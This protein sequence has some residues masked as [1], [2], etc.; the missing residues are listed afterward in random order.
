MVVGLAVPK[1]K[2]TGNVLVLFSSQQ[3]EQRF[4][5][6]KPMKLTYGSAPVMKDKSP[7]YSIYQMA[8]NET[9]QYA[10]IMA[11]LL[12]FK[13]IWIGIIT[14]DDDNGERMVQTLSSI[15]SQH[16]ICIA[17]IERC[18]RSNF[19]DESTNMMQQGARIF[20]KIMESKSNVFVVFGQSYSVNDLRWL[21][22]L[23]PGYWGTK[24]KV[25]ILTA[26]MDLVSMVYQRSWETDII[27]GVLSFTVHFNDLPKFKEIIKNRNP[28]N[29]KGDGFIKDFWQHAFD[30]EWDELKGDSCTGEEK[31]ESLPGVIFEMTMTSHSYS[32]YRAV[33]AVAHAVHAMHSLHSKHGMMMNR[34]WLTPPGQD[35]WQVRLEEAEMRKHFSKYHK[36]P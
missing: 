2:R 18:P 7:G 11:L 9:L 8:P 14:M 6:E 20:A 30:C 28:S 15:F 36:K 3:Q 27:H 21:P 4:T 22:Q 16:G 25:W 32:I 29:A 34:M 13:W 26:Q 33:Y 1:M 23:S 35:Q 31:L 12:H 5:H 17:L 10:G 19:A 24:G